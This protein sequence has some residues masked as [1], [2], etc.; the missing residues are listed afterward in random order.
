VAT[1][2][3]PQGA[4]MVAAGTRVNSGCCFDYGNGETN[5]VNG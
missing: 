1:G 3:E 2:S 5:T 4:Y